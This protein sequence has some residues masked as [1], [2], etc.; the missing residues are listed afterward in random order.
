[1]KCEVSGEEGSGGGA[2]HAEMDAARR[3]ERR[4]ATLHSDP[5][6]LGLKEASILD[7]PHRETRFCSTRLRRSCSLLSL[8]GQERMKNSHGL[9]K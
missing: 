5:G 4:A 6:P 8:V 3:A 2:I 7:I 9:T 1:M